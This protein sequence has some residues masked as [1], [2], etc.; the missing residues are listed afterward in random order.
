MATNFPI[1]SHP[2][3]AKVIALKG[4]SGET[5]TA[6]VSKDEN[7][8]ITI[9]VTNPNDGHPETESVTMQVPIANVSKTGDT[10]TITIT[11]DSGTTT[12]QIHDG[13]TV[14]GAAINASGHLII[15]LSDSSTI[16]AGEVRDWQLSTSYNSTTEA[17]T[18]SIESEV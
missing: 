14:T 6:S 5:P 10:A 11:D 18:L 13:L 8:I 1:Y 4:E 15:T 2:L 17:L 16:D 9:T 3:R 7:G 12:S